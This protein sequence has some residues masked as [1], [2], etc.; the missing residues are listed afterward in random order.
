MNVP[1]GTLVFVVGLCA[2]GRAFAGLGVGDGVG[3]VIRQES[4]GCA[5]GNLGYPQRWAR[6]WVGKIGRSAESFVKVFAAKRS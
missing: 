4:G 3:R 5:A 1:R 2:Q 6:E